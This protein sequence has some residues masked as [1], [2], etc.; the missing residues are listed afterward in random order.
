[1]RLKKC[2]LWMEEIFEW[3]LRSRYIEFSIE[4]SMAD[5]YIEE[6]GICQRK[7]ADE[8]MYYFQG[9]DKTEYAGGLEYLNKHVSDCF[10][11]ALV[12]MSNN[13]GEEDAYVDMLEFLEK[14]EI[15]KV[16]E[17]GIDILTAVTSLDHHVVEVKFIESIHSLLMLSPND[18][19]N[20]LPEMED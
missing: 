18:L 2:L 13:D 7:L 8:T 9:I 5:C 10:R 17:S 6:I 20:L 19:I 3:M 16:T 15:I 1:M 11:A 14:K 4:E 12:Y